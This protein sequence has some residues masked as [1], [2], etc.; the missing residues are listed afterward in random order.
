[1]YT[2]LGACAL[3]TRGSLGCITAC[4]GGPRRVHLASQLAAGL[5]SRA[6]AGG[7]SGELDLT[8]FDLM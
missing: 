7:Q 1:M 8:C 6:R 2:V 5:A 3:L 4:A